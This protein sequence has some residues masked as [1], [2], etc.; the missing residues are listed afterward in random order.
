MAGRKDNGI[1]QMWSS[2]TTGTGYVVCA[3]ISSLHTSPV[4]SSGI[5]LLSF[6]AVTGG[7]APGATRELAGNFIL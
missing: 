1:V 3:E 2:E 4:E 7:V 6:S 5:P